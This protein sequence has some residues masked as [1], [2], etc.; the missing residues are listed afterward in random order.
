M[1]D[2][3]DSS[4]LTSIQSD[5]DVL[6]PP[7]PIPDLSD[8]AADNPPTKKVVRARK[9][10]TQNVTNGVIETN[11][12]TTES[13]AVE[14]TPRKRKRAQKKV[15]QEEAVQMSFLSHSLRHVLRIGAHVSVASGVEKAIP[16]A[17][18]IGYPHKK[19]SCC[20]LLTLRGTAFGMFL[21]VPR[22]WTSAPLTKKNIDAFAENCAEHDFD[23]SRSGPLNCVLG[24]V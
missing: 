21:R 12:V 4:S 9:R 14:T 17:V 3:S 6:I 23:T 1:P 22:K 8:P 13:I 2:A 18:Q 20:L 7:K 5:D 15:K 10:K 16:N 19:P 11:I 24:R